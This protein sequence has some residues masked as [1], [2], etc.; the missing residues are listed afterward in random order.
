MSGEPQ[1]A[2]PRE[3]LV[4]EAALQALSELGGSLLSSHRELERRAERVEAELLR[5][6]QELEA[7]LA[8]LPTGVVVRDAA[9]AAVRA[10]PAARAIA[11]L[12]ADA[13]PAELD[14]GLRALLPEPEAPAWRESERAC[15]D[16]VRRV[17]ATR[18]SPVAGGGSVQLLDDRTELAGLAAR[19][20]QLDKL[21]ALGHMAGG[22]AHELRNPMHAAGGFATLLCARLEEGS[23]ERH[24]AQLIARGVSECE[25]ILASMLTLASPSGLQLEAVDPA[26]LLADAVRLVEEAGEPGDA[27][28][29]IDVQ[30]SA[31]AF[32][33]DRVQLRQAIRNL[34]AN[35]CQVQPMGGRVQ[36]AATLEDG[37]VVVRVADAG[38]GIAPELRARVL[39]PFFTTRARGSGLGLT[40]ADT[41]ARRHGGRLEIAREPSSLGGA[42]VA[43]AVPHRPAI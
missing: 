16:G 5:T 41:I 29:R 38:P 43:L 3:E 1:A 18:S 2:A 39:E 28:M 6:N 26:A 4:L 15:A 31:P 9:G 34:V 33:G 14:R 36:V 11:G 17:L 27:P 20:H 22:I 12:R 40:L 24:W 7:I 21:A 13:S 19:L 8:S 25:R 42:L 32:A 37:E 30:C 23:K 10:N 35:A